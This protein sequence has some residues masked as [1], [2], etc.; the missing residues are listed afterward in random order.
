MQLK[1]KLTSIEFVQIWPQLTKM[2]EFTFFLSRQT[3]SPVDVN[4]KLSF[5]YFYQ[6]RSAKVFLCTAFSTMVVPQKHKNVRCNAQGHVMFSYN[7]VVA[8]FKAHVVS[9][10]EKGKHWLS[11]L[12]ASRQQWTTAIYQYLLTCPGMLIR[13]NFTTEKR[14]EHAQVLAARQ[15]Q[16]WNGGNF[17]DRVNKSR[18]KTLY[19]FPIFVVS[20]NIFSPLLYCLIF[21]G[22][23]FFFGQS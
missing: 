11:C 13:F 15:I 8:W 2:K 17:V 16:V 6:F 5:K 21:V 10:R 14:Y 23:R 4:G 18:L 9:A 3:M 20:T 12:L 22:D 19:A 1:W 7:F